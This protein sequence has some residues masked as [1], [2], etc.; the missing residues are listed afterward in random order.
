MRGQW[1]PSRRLSGRSLPYNRWIES[2]LGINIM[3]FIASFKLLHHVI[4]YKFCSSFP[5]SLSSML[6][7]VLY[8]PLVIAYI[9]ME[10]LSYENHF[11]KV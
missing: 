7:T 6:Y 8:T 9:R 1:E 5:F 3:A 10:C 11:R 4:K 2:L